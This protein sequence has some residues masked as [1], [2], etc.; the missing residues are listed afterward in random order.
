MNNLEDKR[1]KLTSIQFQEKMIYKKKKKK[2][3]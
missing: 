3:V 2:I 1:T